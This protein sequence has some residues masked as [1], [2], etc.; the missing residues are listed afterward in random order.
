MTEDDYRAYMDNL[1]SGQKEFQDRIPKLG[2][3]CCSEILAKE[4]HQKF[5]K[6]QDDVIKKKQEDE[7][8]QK[9]RMRLWQ[10]K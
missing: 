10:R 6:N 4:E 7:V 1:L 8:R 9:E 3:C 5:K 2:F